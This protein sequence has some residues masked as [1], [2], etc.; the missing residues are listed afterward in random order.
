M[1]IHQHILN[2]AE[3]TLAAVLR[4][5][6]MPLVSS[7]HPAWIFDERGFGARL[8]PAYAKPSMCERPS[9]RPSNERP[10]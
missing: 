7:L 4:M 3:P 5:L 9:V 1:S 8:R 10:A 6:R 2:Q